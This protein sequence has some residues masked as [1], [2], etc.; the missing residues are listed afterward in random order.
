MG[1]EN[2]SKQSISALQVY[3]N[4]QTVKHLKKINVE[5]QMKFYISNCKINF[6][7]MKYIFHY[8][9]RM[10]LRYFTLDYTIHIKQP[11]YIQ[12]LPWKQF[13][14]KHLWRFLYNS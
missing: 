1:K 5:I 2:Q 11:S 3:L 10:P 7:E 13:I 4:Q 12:I 14:S 9:N 8:L 6:E